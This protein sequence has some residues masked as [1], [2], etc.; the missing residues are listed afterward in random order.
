MKRWA[1][2]V[3]CAATASASAGTYTDPATK[4][5]FPDT[6]GGWRKTDVKNYSEPGLGTSVSYQNRFLGFATVYIYNKGVKKI[7]TGAANDVVREEF[8]V[9]QQEIA[10]AYANE[11]YENV[12]KLLEAAPE[13]KKDGNKKATVLAAAYRY[14]DPEERPPQRVSFALLTGY[15]NR[16]LKLRYTLPADSEKTPERGQTELRQIITAFLEANKQNSSGFWHAADTKQK[17]TI[18]REEVRAAIRDFKADPFAAL[19]RG[20]GATIINFAEASSEVIVSLDKKSLP[21]I[22]EQNTDEHQSLLLVAYI[23]GNL[24]AQLDRGT[25]AN[26][27]YAGVRQV[28]STYRQIQKANSTIRIPEVE[29]LIALENK[30]R[31]KAHLEPD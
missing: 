14:S 20:V 27:S 29:E 16:F 8:A 31:L 24:E 17:N 1:V 2:A 7:P 26:H 10:A 25:K 15:R 19:K 4:L 22:G 28:I 5:R 21:W 12:K 13:V 6:L 23:A 3:F 9:V 30:G 11:K 18:T